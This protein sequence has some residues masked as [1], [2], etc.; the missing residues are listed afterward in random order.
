MKT[1]LIDY[2]KEE[3]DITL[4]LQAGGKEMS[5]MI[6]RAEFELWLEREGKLNYFDL[7]ITMTGTVE[8]PGKMELP[9]YW[10]CNLN[11]NTDLLSYINS[12]KVK[13][14]GILHKNITEAVWWLKSEPRFLYNEDTGEDESIGGSTRSQQIDYRQDFYK[15]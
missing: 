6:N 12:N 10:V 8:Q 9:D 7:V 15:D 1:T 14:G 3:N 2:H 13:C 5:V 4:D 11:I